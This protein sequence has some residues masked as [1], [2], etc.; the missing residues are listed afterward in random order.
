MPSQVFIS[1]PLLGLKTRF[2]GHEAVMNWYII[3][4][5]NQN[6]FAQVVTVRILHEPTIGY[7]HDNRII[8]PTSLD[9]DKNNIFWKHWFFFSHEVFQIYIF[10]FQERRVKS[11]RFHFTSIDN[12]STK[13]TTRVINWCKNCLEQMVL[14]SIERTWTNSDSCLFDLQKNP[15]NIACFTCWRL[16]LYICRKLES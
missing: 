15:K 7:I 12:S 1:Q 5:R 3:L 8:I 13:I 4:R 11:V 2:F 16:E 10:S 14:A 6:S 9:F